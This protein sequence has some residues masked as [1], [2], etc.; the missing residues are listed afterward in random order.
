MKQFAS[1][2][3]TIEC[4]CVQVRNIRTVVVWRW[5]NDPGL[6]L[7][8]GTLLWPK[9]FFASSLLMDNVAGGE[10]EAQCAERTHLA[11]DRWCPLG[12]LRALCLPVLRVSDR[13]LPVLPIFVFIVF[14]AYLPFGLPYFSIN[15]T[16]SRHE[17]HR[18]VHAYTWWF[19]YGY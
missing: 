18:F 5:C 4:R 1:H 17:H 19:C 10:T 2:A 6:A 13:R 11:G 15:G 3:A 7:R 8:T 16:K 12:H 14:G 9:R